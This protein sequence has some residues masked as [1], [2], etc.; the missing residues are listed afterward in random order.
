MQKYLK[1][2]VYIFI[3]SSFAMVCLYRAKT[4]IFIPFL[5]KYIYA[6]TGY[7][8]KLDDFCISPFSLTLMNVTANDA[9]A[10]QKIK[11]KFKL[12]KIFA[13]IASPLKLISRVDISKLEICLNESFK[14]GNI[15]LDKENIADKLP[16]SGITLFADET[17]IKNNTGCLKIAN[18]NMLIKPCE[19][20]V[21]SVIYILGIPVK[22]SSSIRRAPSGSFNTFAAFTADS[23]VNILVN[24]CGTLDLSSLNMTQDIAVEKLAYNGFSL[25]GAFGAFS[26]KAGSYDVDLWGKFGKFKFNYLPDHMFKAESDV[27]ISKINGSM[28]GNINLNFKGLNSTRVL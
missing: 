28:S 15:L 1:H 24:S 4:F 21:D 14:T 8:V 25:N 19:I 3:I 5:Q 22:F 23:K 16:D 10:M 18:T 20:D 2:T 6:K 12:T 26:K 11:F 7:E 9:V 27:D 13:Y 17:V